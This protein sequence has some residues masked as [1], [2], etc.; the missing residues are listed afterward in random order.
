MKNKQSKKIDKKAIKAKLKKVAFWSLNI[1]CYVATALFIISLIVGACST[2]K[3]S[4]KVDKPVSTMVLRDKPVY[5]ANDTLLT[6]YYTDID[7]IQLVN[8]TTFTLV[9]AYDNY[10]AYKN[11]NFFD[12]NNLLNSSI[13]VG[14]TYYIQM[15][16][17]VVYSNVR[18]D[19]LRL[20]HYN[21]SQ[22][23]FSLASS[24]VPNNYPRIASWGASVN[25]GYID[26]SQPVIYNLVFSGSV[27]FIVRVDNATSEPQKLYYRW[28][29][30]YYSNYS[31]HNWTFNLFDN[32]YSTI[33]SAI[34]EHTTNKGSL[35][36]NDSLK[37][38]FQANS[39]WNYLIDLPL[40]NGG[41]R[42]NGS[43]YNELGITIG[44]CYTTDVNS[45][46]YFI[47]SYGNGLSSNEGFDSYNNN[48]LKGYF[49]I[50][51]FYLSNDSGSI[52][53]YSL[54]NTYSS[55][56]GNWEYDISNGSNSALYLNHYYQS[57]DIF[58]LSSSKS[59]IDSNFSFLSIYGIGSYRVGLLIGSYVPLITTTYIPS[60]D[61]PYFFLKVFD[62]LSLAFNGLMP[63]L[64]FTIMPGISLGVI[65]LT[66]LAI[67]LILF[68][69]KLFKR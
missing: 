52:T 3:Q 26:I 11:P 68:I 61:N 62:W 4:A 23:I 32:P 12:F 21:S 45:R 25:N 27:K 47:T 15:T 55:T 67:T 7:N 38:Y 8:N 30:Y 44:S 24:I 28:L 57:I 43:Y 42:A 58:Y 50:D 40:L 29:L 18:Y 60:T 54:P 37:D 63:I 53:F 14:D 31:I 22:W 5:R 46:Y 34:S 64:T 16:E 56:L 49:F 66:P 9:G 33:V 48:S 41:F 2:P 35:F 10:T 6:D 65:L 51:G 17:G 39:L 36:Y 19:L 69:V 13:F 1:T 20:Y 59:L